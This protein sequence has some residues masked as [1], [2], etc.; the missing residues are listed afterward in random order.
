[1]FR[2]VK[3]LACLFLF[4]FAS[5]VYGQDYQPSLE[6]TSPIKACSDQQEH[7]SRNS[8]NNEIM[9]SNLMTLCETNLNNWIKVQSDS[10]Q[11]WDLYNQMRLTAEKL[12]SY[13]S[14][15]YES[16]LES[17]AYAEKLA[18]ANEA[19]T[20]E[21]ERYR[22]RQRVYVGIAIGGVTLGV[23]AIALT[24]IHLMQGGNK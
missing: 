9:F 16:Y 24:V 10:E 13:S 6:D 11:L 18:V 22:S 14:N 20:Q 8:E 2:P 21:N 1:M 5:F 23:S 3:L 7:N 4:L 15:M 17:A 19:L 12:Q